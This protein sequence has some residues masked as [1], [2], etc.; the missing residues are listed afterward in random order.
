MWIV[1]NEPAYESF[2]REDITFQEE[3]DIV[4]SCS[5]IKNIRNNLRLRTIFN[6]F[7]QA[8]ALAKAHK[9]NYFSAHFLVE[10]L[11]IELTRIMDSGRESYC[12]DSFKLVD[13]NEAYDKLCTRVS[14]LMIN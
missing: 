3:F 12:S 4:L 6:L 8:F 11:D 2:C 5:T 14:H 1:I 9:F 13:Y 7:Y 10:M